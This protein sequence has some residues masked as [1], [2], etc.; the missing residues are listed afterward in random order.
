[1]EASSS[2]QAGTGVP[3]AGWVA[4]AATLFLVL[5]VF[6]V[7][8]GIVAL[9]EDEN[10]VADEL[11]FGDLAFWGVVM[12]IIGLTQLVTGWLLFAGNPAGV[13]LGVLLA[14]LNL[15]AQLF[16]L[17]AFPIWS[18]IIM[19]VD[20]MVIYGLTVYGDAFARDTA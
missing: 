17:P 20:V 15:V 11:F 5:G 14:S 2:R 1:M 4:F 7:I 12:L 19:V 3:G 8:D 10:F 18:I 13:V 16:F 9:A 6:N